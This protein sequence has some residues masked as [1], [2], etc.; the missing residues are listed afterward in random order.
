MLKNRLFVKYLSGFDQ[1]I[2]KLP[3][4]CPFNWSSP[5]EGMKT[6]TEKRGTRRREEKRGGEGRENREQWQT[7][8]GY[9]SQDTYYPGHDYSGGVS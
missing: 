5:R 3:W 7:K 9:H 8:R 6:N 2:A 4:Q 1:N